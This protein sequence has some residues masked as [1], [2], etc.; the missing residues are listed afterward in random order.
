MVSTIHSCVLVGLTGFTATVETDLG[1]GL[2]RFDV[3]GLPDASVKESRD[4]VYAAIKNCGYTYPVSRITVNLAPGELKKEG[5]IYDLPI[6]VGILSASGQLPTPSEKS[7]MIG[8]L[9]L[10]GKVR[11]ANGVLCMAMH[12]KKAGIEEFFVPEDNAAE[13]AMVKGLRIYPVKD[14][15]Q[16]AD[17]LK[18]VKLIEA[19]P[20]TEYKP[21]VPES[22]DFAD[23][24]GQETAKR[25]LI[26]AAAGGH[27]AL[28]IGPPGSGKS[29]LA[30]RLPSILPDLSEQEALE[31]TGV[32]SVAGM[33]PRGDAMIK[34]RPVRSPHHSISVNGLAGGGTHPRPGEIS[35]AHNGVLFLDELPEFHRDALETLRQ[36][37]E[38]GQ[39]TISR[40]SASCTYP[41]RFMM[42]CAMNPCRCGYYGHPTKSCICSD[43]Q[44]RE[45]RKRISGPLLDRIDI[46]VT[47]A[48]LPY[49]ELE[50]RPKGESS[51]S[52]REKI[53]AARKIQAQRYAPYGITTNSQ[54]T[55]ALM[56]KFCTP[57]QKGQAL[58]KAAYDKLGLSAR[59]YD[60][61]L[62]L[63]RTI[64]DL[65]G[66]EEIQAAHIA[67]AIQYRLLDREELI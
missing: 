58:L 56:E 21:E 32:Y 42:I 20:H 37:L 11:A 36:P 34:S 26:I 7:A 18:G 41:S 48:P 35:L 53:N 66:S 63:A 62:K 52:I 5:P 33:L 54:L 15:H 65:A 28:L 12:L 27:H 51:A 17:H 30:K 22:L 19:A 57:D 59:G 6:L 39:V 47:V 16:L 24:I 25:A 61:L 1:R 49:E 31:S 8:E 40:V 60:K 10:E 2:P 44:L 64:A 13:A 45:Y 38:D 50:K 9:S 3:V 67:E 46:H 29:M 55:P 4:R 14:V 43:H 23:V